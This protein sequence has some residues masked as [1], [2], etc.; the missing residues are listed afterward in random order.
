LKLSCSL[1]TYCSD[2]A[3]LGSRLLR[4][5]FGPKRDEVRGEWK[6]L[7]K[8]E[9]YDLVKVKAKVKPTL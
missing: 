4:N 9:F 6:R 5:I 8:E 7:G 2:A 3:V 1:Y